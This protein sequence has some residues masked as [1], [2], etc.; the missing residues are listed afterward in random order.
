MIAEADNNPNILV[1]LDLTDLS[2]IAIEHAF[3]IA[4]Q[5]AADLHFCHWVNHEDDISSATEKIT[6][7]VNAAEG[8]VEGHIEY[9]I[10]VKKGEYM[11]EI[12]DK[13]REL[14]AMLVII[15]THR[16]QGFEFFV[17][18]HAIRIVGEVEAPVM[19]VQEKGV[20]VGGYK[21]ITVPMELE[22]ESKQKLPVVAKMA[23]LFGSTVH[24]FTPSTNDE[25]YRNALWRNLKYAKDYL[26]ERRIPVTT[27]VAEERQKDLD[28][29]VEKQIEK[30]D[31]N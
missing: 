11:K 28:E 3:H 4:Q 25:Y 29:A 20:P 23:K 1:P 15:G 5:A 31:T 22:V 12:A 10:S 8:K 16:L 17:G 24:L 19:V 14:K 21:H 27:D 30:N 7:L 9:I 13:S 2:P 6:E 26:Q 18:T